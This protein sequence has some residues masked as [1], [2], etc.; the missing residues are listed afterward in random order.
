MFVQG[1]ALLARPRRRSLSRLN[2]AGPHQQD[3]GL[4]EFVLLE[5]P[6]ARI[7]DQSPDALRGVTV[8]RQDRKERIIK[9][10]RQVEAA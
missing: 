3:D 2:V 8:V 6:K 7:T 9:L 10:G 5:L 1:P 4:N